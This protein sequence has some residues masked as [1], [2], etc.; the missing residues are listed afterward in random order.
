MIDRTNIWTAA[1]LLLVVV[2]VGALFFPV[3]LVN[4][5]HP[6][7]TN[8]EH[9]APSDGD[10]ILLEAVTTTAISAPDQETDEIADDVVITTTTDGA[11]TVSASPTEDVVADSSE[12]DPSPDPEAT[13]QPE[14]SDWDLLSLEEKIA[15]NP[16]NCDLIG[17]TEVMWPDGSCHPLTPLAAP[18]PD[19]AAISEVVTTSVVDDQTG[20]VPIASSESSQ[21]TTPTDEPTW[22]NFWLGFFF[23]I[24]YGAAILFLIN[25]VLQKKKSK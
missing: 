14:T 4:G 6:E 19:L 9:S 24:I 25:S 7:A 20:T 10:E 22:Y 2:G 15:L 13:A 23:G 17:E 16:N 1:V 21:D 5:D 11:E 3:G 18:S 12:S 8:G